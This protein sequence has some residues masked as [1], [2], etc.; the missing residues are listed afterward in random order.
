MGKAKILIVEDEA[1]VAADL[2]GKLKQLGYDVVGKAAAGDEALAMTGRR[3]P[4]LVLMDIS[5]QGSMDGTEVAAA[6]RNRYD[7]PVVYLTAHSDPATLSRANLTGPFGY[8]LKPFEDRD[9]ATQIELALHKYQIDRELRKQREWL[10]VT[11]ASIG[12]AVI[13]TDA[14]GRISLMNRVA[15]RLTGWT[16]AEAVGQPVQGVLR[17]VHKQKRMPCDE[18]IANT[19][20]DHRA[21]SLEHDTS[22]V[23]K[24]GQQVYIES[25]AAPIRDASGRVIG[26]VLVFRDVTEKR[27]AE[28]S[29][30]RAKEDW[31]ETFNAV[32]DCVAILDKQHRIIRANQAMA[33]RLHMKADQCVGLH[34]Y[35]I[36]HG[37][38]SPMQGCPHCHTCQEAQE[39]AVEVDESR[40]GGSF[41]VTTTPR[42]DA[43]GSVVGTV[44]VAR[45]VTRLKQ[46]E[47]ALHAMNLDLERRVAEQ[48]AAIRRSYETVKAERQRF[49]DLLE[50]LPVYIVL[51]TP[52]QRAHFANRYFRERFG[53]SLG[54]CCLDFGSQRGERHE[55]SESAI[56]LRSGEPRR[57]ESVLPDGHICDVYGFPFTDTDGSVLALEMG[58]DITDRRRAESETSRMREELACVERTARMGEVAASL[59]HEIKQP[60]TA[61][62]TNAQAACRFIDSSTLEIETVRVILHDVIRDTERAGSVVRGLHA[63][64]Q[65]GQL[66]HETLCPIDLIHEVAQLLR[67]EFVARNASLSVDI[68][69]VL[70]AVK[71][72]RVELQQ[73]LVN[74]LVN[75][76]DAVKN[77]PASNREILLRA[78]SDG[79]QVVIDVRDRGCGI[80]SANL[81]TVF[82]PYFTT[83]PTGLGM[84]LTICRRIIQSHN[85]HIWATNN[86]DGGA[87]VSFAIPSMRP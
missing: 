75:A 3:R 27:Q 21:L 8:I 76:L 17:I 14:T 54:W 32:P 2:A 72:K 57:W 68:T 18:L 35:E 23:Q 48:T 44:H 49:Y 19:P 50:A 4:H 38:N 31:E 34:C 78:W 87:T 29:L 39:H 28:E 46:T 73:V 25:N 53:K 77:Q 12:E 24:N 55:E 86:Q 30:R 82:E 70:P 11:L 42:R 65:K 59:A 45:D 7:L 60:L 71:A 6:I 74:L 79:P 63:M 22:L 20:G 5:L 16:A 41:L 43:Q 69:G 64:L 26:S 58:I 51:L 67:S 66:E 40:L 47:K 84:G 10:Q 56:V 13:A 9:L 52:D 81:E 1:I 36:V 80:H 83:K 62:L 15:E 85:G 33:N 61:I 37:T